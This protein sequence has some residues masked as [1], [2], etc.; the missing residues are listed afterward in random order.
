MTGLPPSAAIRMASPASCGCE[1][2]AARALASRGPRRRGWGLISILP[3]RMHRRS[4]ARRTPNP[5][6]PPFAS[7]VQRTGGP[8]GEAATA[9]QVS[10][11][12][13]P[14]VAGAVGVGSGGGAQRPP[15]PV[16]LVARVTPNA[17]VPVWSSYERRVAVSIRLLLS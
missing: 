2:Q 9:R 17:F 13:G 4:T 3:V 16:P 14:L 8:S 10:T 15:L 11:P 1:I 12:G 5:P 6:P 7:R